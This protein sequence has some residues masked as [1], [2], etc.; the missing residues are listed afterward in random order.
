MLTQRVTNCLRK[1]VGWGGLA[2]F[3]DYLIQG[4]VKNAVIISLVIGI[5]A[6]LD[7]KY[8]EQ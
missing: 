2:G 6:V 4:Q 8:A 3:S 5:T 7:Y 1:F